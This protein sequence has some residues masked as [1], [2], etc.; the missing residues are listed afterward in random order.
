MAA[1]GTGLHALSKDSI[2]FPCALPVGLPSSIRRTLLD[3]YLLELRERLT[4]LTQTKRSCSSK[5]A[6]SATLSHD[7]DSEVGPTAH[8]RRLLEG[9]KSVWAELGD[10]VRRKKWDRV[11][12]G[13]TP[14]Q[15]MSWWAEMSEE[16]KVGLTPP[17]KAQKPVVVPEMANLEFQ[18]KAKA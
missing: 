12:A 13:L 3:K 4:A 14:E 5:S 10:E 7:G 16:L 15:L 8:Q 1:G 11:G 6:Q 2:T 18:A 17:E 9:N